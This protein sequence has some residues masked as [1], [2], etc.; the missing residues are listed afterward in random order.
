MRKKYKN[1]LAKRKAEGDS[2]Y[3]KNKL[4][5]AVRQI[6]LKRDGNCCVF[7]GSKEKPNVHHIIDRRYKPY[8][9]DPNNLI[10]LCSKCHKFDAFC[11]VHCNPAKFLMFLKDFREEQW[12]WIAEHCT[13]PVSDA[14][15]S[16]MDI[17][18]RLTGETPP[19]Q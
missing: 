15:E 5:N 16:C 10:S 14:G 13:T 8:R 7:C 6:V 3:W 9:Y 19:V 17:Y 4:W 12:N 2:K 1:P 18:Y 11:S